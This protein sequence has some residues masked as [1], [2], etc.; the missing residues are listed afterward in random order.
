MNDSTFSIRLKEAFPPF[1]SIL[2]SLYCSVVPHEVIT[3][4]GKDFRKHPVG[5]GPFKFKFWEGREKFAEITRIWIFL[6]QSFGL[7]KSALSLVFAS[8]RL[9]MSSVALRPT[10]CP[11]T[12]VLEIFTEKEPGAPAGTRG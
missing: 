4:Y 3:E 10:R 6:E 11:E 8:E 5:T 2:T 9:L 12:K 1:L 7:I